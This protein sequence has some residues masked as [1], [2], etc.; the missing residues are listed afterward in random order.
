M[1]NSWSLLYDA[2]YGP[3]DE[4]NLIDWNKMYSGQDP[5]YELTADGFVWPSQMINNQQMK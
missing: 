4:K 5:N 2:M 3:E 1:V